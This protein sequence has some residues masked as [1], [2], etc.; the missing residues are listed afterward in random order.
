M[1]CTHIF[2]RLTNSALLLHML[3]VWEQFIE[4]IFSSTWKPFS[5]RGIIIANVC[6]CVIAIQRSHPPHQSYGEQ[7]TATG[8]P[9]AASTWNHMCDSLCN[10]RS[11]LASSINDRNL[12]NTYFRYAKIMPIHTKSRECIQEYKSMLTVVTMLYVI[13][14]K[15]N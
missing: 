5:I 14:I 11:A 2:E 7:R 9:W 4:C 8:V 10:L 12:E 6:F 13:V 1:N 3:Q 15:T